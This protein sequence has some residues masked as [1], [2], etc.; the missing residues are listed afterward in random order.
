MRK[1]LCRLSAG[2]LL[3]LA[4]SAASAETAC[5]V[6]GA[7]IT[8]NGTGQVERPVARVDIRATFTAQARS[9]DEARRSLTAAFRPLV[10][11]LES[12]T[13]AG[14]RLVAARLSIHPQWQT[15]DGERA[16]DGYQ[17]RRS[18]ELKA[19]PVAAAGG[20]IER[21][22]VAKPTRLGLDNEQADP[23]ADPG[24]A[25]RRAFDDARGKAK[26]LAGQT[27]RT[28]GDVR[29]IAERSVD[30]G[31][32]PRQS[33]SMTLGRSDDTP[34]P[35]IRPGVITERARVEVVFGLRRV[36]AGD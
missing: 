13:S 15:T 16:I 5:H 35:V 1:A 27:D 2:W 11:R 17:A 36:S 20:W 25:L 23:G 31:P 14:M 19:V 29:C 6:E 4:V 21:L 3:A 33:A 10:E 32:M 34:A 18:L 12:Q 30:G 7:T 26:V 8:V 28:L 9:P 22:A 24:E